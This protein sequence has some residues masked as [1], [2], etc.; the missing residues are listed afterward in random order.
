LLLRMN[1]KRH[2]AKSDGGAENYW[3]QGEL[4]RLTRLHGFLSDRRSTASGVS[5]VPPIT[6][7]PARRQGR[8]CECLYHY[9]VTVNIKISCCNSAETT[10]RPASLCLS[11]SSKY[12]RPC[13]EYSP[14]MP[15]SLTTL[16][17]TRHAAAADE[18]TDWVEANRYWAPT[19]ESS[20]TF[21]RKLGGGMPT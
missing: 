8:N 6:H 9:F 1:D 2:Q 3:K 12:V 11:K 17:A 15:I 19:Q 7:V 10:V 13:L 21:T 16:L 5:G 4:L 14:L 18:H 20:S